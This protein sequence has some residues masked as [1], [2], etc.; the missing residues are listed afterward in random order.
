MAIITAI[1]PVELQQPLLVKSIAK[2]SKYYRGCCNTTLLPY[3]GTF[4]HVPGLPHSLIQQP[5][6]ILQSSHFFLEMFTNAIVKL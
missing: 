4:T 1:K 3:I 6:W 5:C 2:P